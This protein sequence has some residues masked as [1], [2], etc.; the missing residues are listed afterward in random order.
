MTENSEFSDE[1]GP[2]N[3]VSSSAG[4]AEL[5]VFLTTEVSTTE[6]PTPKIDSERTLD[7]RAKWFKESYGSSLEEVFG[8]RWRE[9]TFPSPQEAAEM[10]KKER[11]NPLVG[12]LPVDPARW[13]EDELLH[14]LY[15]GEFPR[16]GQLLR[17]REI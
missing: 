8:D 10:E 7:E 11:E 5:E 12:P 13:T 4:N 1:I 14:N 15:T 2:K 17:G 9:V 16:P 3:E 6:V